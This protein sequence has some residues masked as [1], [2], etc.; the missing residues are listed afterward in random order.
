MI[1]PFGANYVPS[2][3]RVIGIPSAAYIAFLLR[4][5][6]SANVEMACAQ[7]KLPQEM[8][9]LVF[10]QTHRS[11]IFQE[12]SL[13]AKQQ[14]AIEAFLSM[15]SII[16]IHELDDGDTIECHLEH[17]TIKQFTFAPDFYREHLIKAGLI[18][19]E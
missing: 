5:E 1:D 12:T 4:A 16:K 11:V 7:F 8:E 19:A 17:E 6:E 2:L 9:K 14:C 13:T 18:S 3:A 10:F 15:L